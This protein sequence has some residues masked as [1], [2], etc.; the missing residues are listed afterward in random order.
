VAHREAV[1]EWARAHDLNVSDRGRLAADVVR[2]FEEATGG[3]S[4]SSNGASAV[5]EAAE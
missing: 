5:D 2:Q 3:D 1:R 4:A